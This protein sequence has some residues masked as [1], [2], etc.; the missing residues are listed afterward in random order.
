VEEQGLNED[1]ADKLVREKQITLADIP[2]I[3]NTNYGFRTFLE[4]IFR[5]GTDNIALTWQNQVPD[6]RIN[7]AILDGIDNRLANITTDS[8]LPILEGSKFNITELVKQKKIILIP[9]TEP[10]FGIK[11]K[12]LLPQLMMT[13]LWAELQ[14]EQ[15]PENKEKVV[16]IIDEVEEVQLPIIIT[17]LAQARKYGLSLVLAN[18]YLFQL[19][20]WFTQAILGNVANLFIFKMRN[21]DEVKYITPLFNGR[22]TELDITGLEKFQG[23]L[24]T[25]NSDSRGSNVLSFETLDYNE[26]YKEKSTD[27]DIRELAKQS[28]ENYGQSTK[29]LEQ[30]RKEKM[31]NGSKWFEI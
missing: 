14:R 19:K 11:G 16:V 5:N 22:V 4:E 25:L 27:E 9:N 2:F 3:L 6:M 30:A 20:E 15:N 24:T 31:T 8:I 21:K 12:R 1:E 18:Q 28:L 29:E 23:Y 7:T 17:M 10:L 13:E 26:Y